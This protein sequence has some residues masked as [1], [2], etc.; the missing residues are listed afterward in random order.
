MDAILHFQQ[1][2][3]LIVRHAEGS[4]DLE[5][6]K[7][8]IQENYE[9]APENICW[10]LLPNCSGRNISILDAKELAQ[11]TATFAEKCPGTKSAIV[12]P[13]HF[14]FAMGRI[15]EIHSGLI[16]LPF[17]VKVFRTPEKAAEWLEVSVKDLE[18]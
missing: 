13:E 4:P 1:Y 15:V 11:Y 2:D 3:N 17:E 8:A 12:A 5:T 14:E 6:I 7:A 16:D 9:T 10:I 18:R